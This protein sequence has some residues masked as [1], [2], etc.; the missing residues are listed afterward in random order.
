MSCYGRGRRRLAIARIAIRAALVALGAALVACTRTAMAGPPVVPTT[1]VAVTLDGVPLGSAIANRSAAATLFFDSAAQTFHL[2]TAVVDETGAGDTAADF[3][4]LRIS[5]Y[6]HATSADGMRFTTTGTLAFAG[7]PFAAQVYGSTFGEPAW[8]YPKFA[9]WNGRNVLMLWTQNATFTP[10]R[11][12]DYNYNISFNDVGA[13]ASNLTLTHEGPVGAV[14]GNA[15]AGQTAGAYGI[16]RGV[17]YYDNNGLLGRAALTDNGPQAFPANADTGPWQVTAN[18]T[19]V[20]DLLTPLGYV[21]CQFSGGDA[22][23]HNDA[24]VVDN[25]DATLGLFY[26]LR[27]CDGSR[28]LQQIFYM[29]SADNG[30]SW[31]APVGIVTAP[32]NIDG[33]APSSGLS[34]TDVVVV[35]GARVVYMNYVDSNNHLVVGARPPAVQ[36][37]VPVPSGGVAWSLSLI[38]GLMTLATASVQRDRRRVR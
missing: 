16:V 25:G 4:P 9:Q 31:S 28:K 24:R 10:Q 6:R 8:I 38:L 2:W 15:I 37:A 29:E 35:R 26:T 19:A 30:L 21:A 33:N 32:V 23:V 11:F 14:P 7:N 18:N 36:P 1:N 12:G 34:L 20:A 5:G 13:S 27:N 22:Y 3:Y 17:M